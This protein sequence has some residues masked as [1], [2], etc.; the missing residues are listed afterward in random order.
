MNRERLQTGWFLSH[1]LSPIHNLRRSAACLTLLLTCVAGP[2]GAAGT[3]YV[4]RNNPN[5]S[6]TGPGTEAIPYK[7]IQAACNARGGAGTTINVK[8]GTYREQ[9][10]I[11]DS[12]AAGSPYVIRAITKPVIVDGADD[13]G[14]T[15]LWT[16]EAN[17]AF[18]AASVTWAPRQVFANGARLDSTALAVGSM[19][20]NSFT[21]VLGQGLYVKTD[22]GNP[23]GD[24]LLVGHRTHGFRFNARN[25]VTVDG[26]QVARTEDHGIYGLTCSNLTVRNMVVTFAEAHG[27]ALLGGSN[28][29][30]ELNTVT[31][32]ADHGINLLN[33]VTATI[34]QDNESARNARRVV[35]AANGIMLFGS[36]NNVIQR[37][38]FHHNE[39][40]GV[41]VTN[42]SAN[43]RFINN[44][45]WLNGDHGFDNVES[46]GT[47]HVNNV[48]WGNHNDGISVE[49]GSSSIQIWTCIL[50]DNGLTTNRFNLFADSASVQ[51]FTSNFNIIWNSTTQK[52][53]KYDGIQ[54]ATVL[55]F[56]QASGQD[57]NSDQADPRFKS[58]STGDFHVL[59]GSKAIDT[60]HSGAPFW[61]L[62]DAENRARIDD[63]VTP[64]AGMGPITYS[65]RGA[66][67]FDRQGSVGVDDPTV[68]RLSLGPAYP[69]P[70]RTGVSFSLELAHPGDVSWY[71]TDVQGRIV[72]EE[73]AAW[74][75]GR[76]MI[77]WSGL[78]AR[79][80]RAPAGIYHVRVH[81]QGEV[82]ARSFA[83]IH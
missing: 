40:S 60:G 80:R 70:A 36:S 25:Y 75:A 21:F 66:L 81:A 74:S 20:A 50:V 57:L 37:N 18:R 30:I 43:N 69:N 8:A 39:D 4:D 58:A 53:I 42:N 3:F 31:D 41:E 63:P 33:G 26:F 22:G 68:A 24:L 45:C 2:A 83:V 73:R 12:G 28:N 11:D 79:G 9:V 27:I 51:G 38:R 78:T 48:A 64:N 29:L 7:T 35:R 32:C 71:V 72:F 14:N 65:D 54:Y 59:S 34:V 62:K 5:A 76:G 23:G 56:S 13:F 19:P 55:A 77:Q 16:A 82:L 17:G 15:G 10:T 47:I 67:E 44:R 61:P 46:T 49:G 52:P 1:P 6:D